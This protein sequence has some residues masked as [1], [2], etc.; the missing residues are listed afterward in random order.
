ML[1]PT[2]LALSRVSQLL[3][4]AVAMS[5]TVSAIVSELPAHADEVAEDP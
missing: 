4:R 3:Y 2:A 1:T 5:A